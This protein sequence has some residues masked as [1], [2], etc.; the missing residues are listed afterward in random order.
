VLFGRKP[1]VPASLRSFDEIGVVTFKYIVQGKLNNRGTPCMCVGYSVHH[2]HDVYRT[3]NLET[4]MITHLRDI[5]W[6]NEVHQ[7]W[8][9]RKVMHQFVDNDDDVME[10][11]ILLVNKGQD[12]FQ[13]VAYQDDLKRMKVYMQMR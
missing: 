5:M 3:L 12:A 2:A 4:E 9:A 8:I 10:S 11:T 1:R 13:G 7:E 6:L